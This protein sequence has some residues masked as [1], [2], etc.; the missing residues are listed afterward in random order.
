MEDRKIISYLLKKQFK[1]H[2]RGF[3]YIKDAINIISNSSKSLFIV[4]D[5]YKPLAEKYNTKYSLVERDIRYAI[6]HSNFTGC[7][8]YEC[9]YKMVL[10]L[11]YE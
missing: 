6:E 3:K 11:T 7:K 9:L 10:E 5:I 2:F 4:N 8:N 1:P